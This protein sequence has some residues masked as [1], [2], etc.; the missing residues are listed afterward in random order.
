M[1]IRRRPDHLPVCRWAAPPPEER[2]LDVRAVRPKRSP[3]DTTGQMT[4]NGSLAG[5]L[6]RWVAIAALVPTLSSCVVT[7]VTSVSTFS[8]DSGH[9][10]AVV[11]NGRMELQ[12]AYGTGHWTGAVVETYVNTQ[13]NGTRFV[14]VTVESTDGYPSSS[15]LEAALDSFEVSNVSNTDGQVTSERHIV[16]AGLEAREQVITSPS[17]EYVFRMV[18]RGQRAWLWSVKGTSITAHDAMSQLF[19]DS[20]ALTP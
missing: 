11:P 9:F 14:V 13:A 18:I 8:S 19:L 4:R 20:F 7:S 3:R 12:S 16:L 10:S 17:A 6:G 2:L 15:Q 5:T 1:R